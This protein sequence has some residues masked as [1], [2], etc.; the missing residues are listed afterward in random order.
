MPNFHITALGDARVCKAS[1]VKCPLGGEALHFSSAKAARAAYEELMS[2]VAAG[3][4]LSLKSLDADGLRQSLFAEAYAVQMDLVAIRKAAELATMLHEGQLRA[5]IP[6][7]ARPPYITHPLRNSVRVIRWGT[8]D[9]AHVIIGLF[10]DIVEDSSLTF[11]KLH[12]IEVRDEAHARE[13]LLA[14]IRENYGD[15][16]ASAVFKLSNPLLNAEDRANRT[17]EQKHK[18]YVEHVAWAIA[19]D[20]DVF[21]LKLSDLQDNAAGLYHT[22]FENRRQQTRRQATKYLKTVP[23]VRA[24]LLRNP[25]S[26]SRIQA[27]AEDSINLIEA[28]LL[29]MLSK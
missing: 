27:A 26:N 13:V 2:P 20:E 14:Y 3:I 15:R 7:E 16:V 5:A 24:E 4:K 23:T 21:L 6:G 29:W 8:K 19:D 18:G 11:A 22:D 10:H 9:T 28:R 1:L 17:V 12:N 25:F